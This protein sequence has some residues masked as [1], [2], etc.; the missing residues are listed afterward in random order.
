M[1]QRIVKL[2]QLFF[3][4]FSGNLA[5]A[6]PIIITWEDLSPSKD[7]GVKINLDENI[8]IRGIPDISE[9]DDSKEQL[10]NFLEEMKYVKEAQEKGGFINMKLNNKNI[11]IPGY[12]TPIT[13]EGENVTEFL[14]VP[15]RGACIHVPPPPSNQ[16]IYVKSAKGLKAEDIWSAKWITGILNATPVSTVVANVGYSIQ[17]A[18][19]SPYRKGWSLFD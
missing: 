17:E 5:H 4:F 12:I 8:D 18:N 13:F 16:I 3:I 11:K 9:F 2:L 19:V 10:D 7:K 1:C 15:Y 14:F 6:E